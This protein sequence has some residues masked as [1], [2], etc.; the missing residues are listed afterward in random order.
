MKNIIY[1]IPFTGIY[2]ALYDNKKAK[3]VMTILLYNIALG[4]IL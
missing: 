3:C 2:L 1:L 4:I